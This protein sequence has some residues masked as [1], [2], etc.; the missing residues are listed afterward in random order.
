MEGRW[1][2]AK[3]VECV[4]VAHGAGE[5]PVGVDHASMEEAAS[6][7]YLEAPVVQAVEPAMGLTS[8]GALLKVFRKGT[9]NQLECQL[10]HGRSV[11][12]AGAGPAGAASGYVECPQPAGA[13][14]FVEVLLGSSTRE[15][16]AVVFQYVGP[17]RL[18][19]VSHGVAASGGVGGVVHVSGAHIPAGAHC[20]VEGQGA[21]APAPGHVVSS[22]LVLCEV[23]SAE[24]GPGEVEVGVGEAVLSTVGVAVQFTPQA[25]ALAVSPAEGS[26]EGGTVVMVAGEG[27]GAS[28]D[29]SCRMG[30]VGPVEGRWSGAKG[31]ECVTVAHAPAN[32]AVSFG[33]HAHDEELAFTYTAW[34]PLQDF[35][36]V[37]EAAF[38]F[39]RVT[40]SAATV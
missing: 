8:G 30:T 5:V 14:G 9:G 26:E 35:G 2:G 27:L 23:S 13:A 11:A 34:A 3:G 38:Y 24:P 12:V 7:T 36:V 40:E 32:V 31:V 37:G 4:T 17:S 15:D 25:R 39:D 29:V 33:H 10:G 21:G 16:G 18:D 1:S 20:V 28:K 19:S 6:F 22:A